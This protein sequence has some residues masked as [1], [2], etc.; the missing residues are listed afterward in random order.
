MSS[1]RSKATLRVGLVVG[2]AALVLTAFGA[3]GA[4]ASQLIDRNAAD[5]TL[6]VNARGEAL[7]TYTARGRVRHVLAWGAVNALPPAEGTQQYF[8][9][10][11]AAQKLVAAFR[12]IQFTPGYLAN[13]VTRDLQQTQQAADLYWKTGFNGG[14]LPYYGAPLPWALI[15][16]KAPDGSYW[17]VQQWQRELPERSAQW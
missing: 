9:Q 13:P 3:A 6:K 14:C 8:A 11:A 1:V 10:N 12:R 16:C 5:V 7:L 17:A 4:G 2:A 15:T